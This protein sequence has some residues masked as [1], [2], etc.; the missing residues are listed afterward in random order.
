M[1]MLRMYIRRTIEEKGLSR[2]TCLMN[3]RNYLNTTRLPELEIAINDID[4]FE[5]LRILWEAGLR[6]PL[7]DAV[8]RRHTELTA[9]RG[10]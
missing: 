2:Q 6:T 4:S 9:R 1:S 10:E 8:L 3:L 5:Q 7:Q